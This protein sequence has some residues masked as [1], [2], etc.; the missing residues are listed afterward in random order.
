MIFMNTTN[1]DKAK[2][3]IDDLLRAWDKIHIENDIEGG[4]GT[5]MNLDKLFKDLRVVISNE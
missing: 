1:T 5:M 2:D 4:S 3:I